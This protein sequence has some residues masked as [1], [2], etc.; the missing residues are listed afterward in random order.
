M[1]S[2]RYDG[3]YSDARGRDVVTFLNDGQTL[4]TAIRGVEF[5]GR[6]FDS[7]S[8]LHGGADLGGFTLNHGELC[9]CSFAFDIP[10]PVIIEKSE[11]SGR[12]H[13]ELEL[14]AP[15]PNGGIE[16]ER[17]KLTLDYAGQRV[18]SSGSSGFFED[19]LMEIRQRMPEGVFIKACI[20]CLFSDYDPSGQPAF[21]GMLCFRNIKAEYLQANSKRDLLQLVERRDRLVQETYLCP[22]FSPRILGTGYRG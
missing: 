7:M 21:G 20:N 16:R 2:G 4:Y 18:V 5:A 9:A 10:V 19:E 3:T 11:I 1:S 12:L 6:D 15:A 13:V 22:E 8:P 14:G 17:V